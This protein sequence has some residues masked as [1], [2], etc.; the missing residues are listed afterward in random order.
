MI[1]SANQIADSHT[2]RSLLVIASAN[3]IAD[4]HTDRI[5]VVIASANQ[6]ADSHTVADLWLWF[7]LVFLSHLSERRKKLGEYFLPVGVYKKSYRLT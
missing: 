2:D 7:T 4:S 3:Q 5:L 6:I 1:A